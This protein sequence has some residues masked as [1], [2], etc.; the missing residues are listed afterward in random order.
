MRHVR[1]LAK[2]ANLDEIQTRIALKRALD[3]I[4]EI[5]FWTGGEIS[6]PPDGY[7]GKMEEPPR[8]RH[9]LPPAAMG[10]SIA[11]EVLMSDM[12]WDECQI[13]SDFNETIKDHWSGDGT[14]AI[15]P[16]QAG[17]LPQKS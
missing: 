3:H 10:Y 17:D 4:S 14:K 8:K 2:R 9:E 1:S 7:I 12:V 11:S 6:P 13:M 16:S 15:D 5:N